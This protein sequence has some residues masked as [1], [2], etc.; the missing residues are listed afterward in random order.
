MKKQQCSLSMNYQATPLVEIQSIKGI[1]IYAKLEGHNPT[2]YVK[3][4]N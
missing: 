3:K 2:G 4:R 1:R